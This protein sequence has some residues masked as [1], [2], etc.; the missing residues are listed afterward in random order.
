[1]AVAD[2]SYAHIVLDENR[3][4]WIAGT[5]TKVVEL[6]AEVKVHGWSAE[7]LAHQHP[8]LTLAQVHS[9]LAYYWDHSA[10]IEEDLRR[11]EQVAEAVREE[12]GQ[13]PLVARLRASGQI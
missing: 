4:P 2:T 6:V 5:R 10:E 11:R 3:V 13:H 1:M 9:A 12:I 7:E 8:H